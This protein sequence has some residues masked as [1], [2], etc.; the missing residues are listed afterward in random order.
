MCLWASAEPWQS[1]GQSSRIVT[2]PRPFICTIFS[3]S[4]LIPMCPHK[5]DQ[6]S[7]VAIQAGLKV[8]V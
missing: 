6:E 8:Y 7:C 1:A 2:L 4:K 5:N 3:K